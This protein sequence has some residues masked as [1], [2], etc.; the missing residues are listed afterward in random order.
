MGTTRVVGT[1][2]AGAGGAAASVAAAGTGG[3]APPTA[4]AGGVFLAAAAAYVAGDRRFPLAAAA[5]AYAGVGGAVLGDYLAPPPAAPAYFGVA[6]ALAAAFL[7]RRWAGNA[8]RL[9]TVPIDPGPRRRLLA[10]VGRAWLAAG[11]AFRRLAGV[12]LGAFRVGTAALVVAWAGAVGGLV[13][14]TGT[15]PGPAGGLAGAGLLAALAVPCYFGTDWRAVDD[16]AASG[17][18][19]TGDR[20]R[21]VAAAFVASPEETGTDG[22]TAA[23]SDSEGESALLYRGGGGRSTDG[24]RSGVESLADRFPAERARSGTDGGDDRGDDG[25]SGQPG[26]EVEELPSVD[27]MGPAALAGGDGTDDADGADGRE[28]D[29]GADADDDDAGDDGAGDDDGPEDPPNE[30]GVFER[31]TEL[32][33]GVGDRREGNDPEGDDR[34][35]DDGAADPGTGATGGPD[36]GDDRWEVDVDDRFDA[37]SDAEADTHTDDDAEVDGLE[38]GAVDEVG[39]DADAVEDLEFGAVD[40]MDPDVVDGVDPDPDGGD[41]SAGDAP[42]G[43]DADGDHAGGGDGESGPNLEGDAVEWVRLPDDEE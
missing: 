28:A 29:G 24:G 3:L 34:E 12:S 41:D 16:P 22:R 39:S 40:E 6:A 19:G 1:L 30:L 18:S 25:G 14:A 32:L 33:E 20:V 31:V 26:V 15:L 43:E 9:A 11:S 36:D 17:P 23:D 4:V 10:R 13:V 5:L 7:V 37:G 21:A 35:T 8:R 27:E 38:F 42:G 2:A